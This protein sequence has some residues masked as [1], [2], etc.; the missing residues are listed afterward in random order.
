M[1]N[2]TKADRL[3]RLRE[4]KKELLNNN[5]KY[6]SFIK[7]LTGDNTQGFGKRIFNLIDE[8]IETELA[9]PDRTITNS[10]ELKLTYRDISDQFMPEDDFK[11]NVPD[12]VP[13]KGDNLEQALKKNSKYFF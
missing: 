9:L 10:I 6:S 1:L 11:Y 7:D 4:R 5:E 3:L 12:N 2:E 13:F 8:K